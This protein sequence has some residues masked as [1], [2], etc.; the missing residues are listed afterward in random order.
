MNVISPDSF[1]IDH[2][3]QNIP[4]ELQSELFQQTLLLTAT[5]ISNSASQADSDLTHP[6]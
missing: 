3:C 5:H 4:L 2:F 1:H 6:H